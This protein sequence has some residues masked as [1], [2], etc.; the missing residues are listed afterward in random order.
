MLKQTK[1]KDWTI[2]ED[3]E[4]GQKTFALPESKVEVLTN[5]S[6]SEISGEKQNPAADSHPGHRELRLRDMRRSSN[7]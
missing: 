7:S 5:W 3:S 1:W 2:L 6:W 4:T